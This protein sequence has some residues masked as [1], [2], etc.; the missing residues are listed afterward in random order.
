MEP[1]G[2]IVLGIDGG[3]ST[4]HAAFADASGRVLGIGIAGAS[5]YQSAGIAATAENIRLAV[6]RARREAGSNLPAA[7]AAFLGM[8]GVLA[9]A[10]RG[11]V[12]DIAERQN[13]AAHIEV[14]HDLRPAL[15]G[16]L[17]GAEGIVLIA[18]TGSSCYGRRSDGGSWRAGGW[19]HLLDDAGGA[20]RVA[21]DGLSAAVRAIDGRGADTLLASTLLQELGIDDPDAILH[22]VHN[23]LDRTAIAALAPLVLAAADSGDDVAAGIL[24]HAAEELALMVGTVHRRLMFNTATPVVT[25]G[26]LFNDARFRD[27]VAHALQR[28]LP[29]VR[30]VAPKHPPVIGACLL[31]RQMSGR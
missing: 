25:I 4:T 24:E 23:Q 18:G 31:A 19:G 29:D 21:V 8:A 7:R 1:E 26:G 6:E 17:D 28:R 9:A 16:G 5:N 12:L 13:L 11:I 15:A 14:D 10:D 27:R 20:Y 2:P 3:G 30:L 22:I